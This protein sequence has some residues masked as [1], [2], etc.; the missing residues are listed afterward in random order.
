MAEFF[1]G[2]NSQELLNL[3]KEN[4]LKKLQLAH[5][6]L[7]IKNKHI[8]TKAA[9]PT[10]QVAAAPIGIWC[11]ASNLLDLGAASFAVAS[12]F[13][14]LTVFTA[15][16]CFY[17]MYKSKEKT[18]NREIEACNLTYLKLLIYEELF[19]RSKISSNQFDFYRLHQ[20]N[21][22]ASAI[23]KSP[24]LYIGLTAATTLFA[25]Y[26]IGTSALMHTIG[27]VSLATVLAGPV[28][29][30]IAGMVAISIGLSIAYKHY[31]AKKLSRNLACLKQDLTN[32]LHIAEGH[33]QGV[34]EPLTSSF[35][36]QTTLTENLLTN[37]SS[38]FFNTRARIERPACQNDFPYVKL[39]S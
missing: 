29:I 13:L 7:Q 2:F 31:Q 3:L 15:A 28:A 5:E 35:S 34:N 19:K 26:Y 37:S 11:A 23:S 21:N 8:L 39:V 10:L 36:K 33:W 27:F 4:N 16:A 25:S 6:N 9:L 14:T 18:I 17:L 24:S 30:A 12:A 38:L 32:R 1:K 20:F 22:Q